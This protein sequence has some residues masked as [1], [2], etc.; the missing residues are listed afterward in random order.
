MTARFHPY[1]IEGE[2]ALPL[3]TDD[4]KHFNGRIVTHPERLSIPLKRRNPTV[5][6]VWNDLF[7]ENISEEFTRDTHWTMQ[8][9]GWHTFLVLTKR[10][11]R[12]ADW[13]RVYS[14]API[15]PHI[16]YGLTVCNQQEA[17]EKIPIFLQVP[18]KKF[19]SIEPCLSEINILPYI[20]G[21][22]HHCKCGW[23]ETEERICM[24]GKHWYCPECGEY[25][26]NYDAI[27]AVILG[28][29]TGPGARPLHP[30]WVRSVRDQC[31]AAAVPFF[32]KGWGEWIGID[33]DQKHTYWRCADGMTHRE[34]KT[35]PASGVRSIKVGRNNSGRILDG[36]THDD[37]PWKKEKAS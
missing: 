28:G 20:G 36:R 31:A 13:F 3:I 21:Q 16:Y 26:E 29:E 11:E 7:H 35:R 6:A 12:I 25:C 30:D 27:N 34:I 33:Y 17:D 10:H 15:L 9:C 1:E 14:D 18:G 4:G 37:L 32:F 2:N 8:R 19:L 24:Q 23:H 22:A 5:Y